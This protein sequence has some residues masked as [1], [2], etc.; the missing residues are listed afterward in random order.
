MFKAAPRA[1]SAAAGWG[2]PPGAPR[3]PSHLWSPFCPHL[4]LRGLHHIAPAYCRVGEAPT[5]E[6]RPDYPLVSGGGLQGPHGPSSLFLGKREV[7]T[8][9][10]PQDCVCCEGRSLEGQIRDGPC[11]AQRAGAQQAPDEC[12]PGAGMVI[13]LMQMSDS[14]V[15]LRQFEG[16]VHTDR[17]HTG[18]RP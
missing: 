11:R 18:F 7:D 2:E 9:S 13:A 8:L 10:G 5:W 6:P 16:R 15:R 14:W 4:P 12:L 17:P 3:P 1:V